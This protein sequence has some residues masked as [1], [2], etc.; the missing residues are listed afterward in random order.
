METRNYFVLITLR[1]GIAQSL[2]YSKA[3]EKVGVG[4]T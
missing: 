1:Y 4:D 3:N 2:E